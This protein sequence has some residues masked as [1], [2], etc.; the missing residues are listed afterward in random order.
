M[1]ITDPAATPGSPLIARLWPQMADRLSGRAAPDLI[2]WAIAAGC[3]AAFTVPVLL[4]AGSAHPPGTEAVFGA[5]AAAPLIVRRK[6]PVAV[7]L[8]VAA[9]YV[10]AALADVAFTPVCQQCGTQSGDRGLHR[11][12]PEPPA[13]VAGG[14]RRGRRRHLGLAAGRHLSASAP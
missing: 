7:V 13:V 1:V 4:S 9:V 8:V 11:G 5:M 3:F 14:G 6:W 12:R 2:D 10:A